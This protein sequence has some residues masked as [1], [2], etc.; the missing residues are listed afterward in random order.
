MRTRG[1]AS[2]AATTSPDFLLGSTLTTPAGTPAS[3][4]SAAMA[5]AVRGVSPAGLR[6]VV[7]PA[8]RAGAILRAAIAAGKFHGV[9]RTAIPTGWRITMILLAPARGGLDLPPDPDGLL[10]VPAEELRGVHHLAAR[11]GQRL[12]VLGADQHGEVVGPLDHQLVRPR[13]DLR[14]LPR[15]GGGPLGGGLCGRVHAGERVVHG[16]AGHGGEHLAGGRVEH[17]E[18]G[19]VGGGAVLAADDQLGRYAADDLGHLP[20]HRYSLC[21]AT[22]SSYSERACCVLSSSDTSETGTS[23]QAPEPP[24][25]PLASTLM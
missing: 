17:L 1:S 22:C 11:V 13:Q 21:P 2:M 6:I 24:K 4:I 7:Q 12:A 3:S 15:R 10:G 20:G 23:H 18:G 16:P 8:A 19:A 5:R 9:T 25:R 14:P